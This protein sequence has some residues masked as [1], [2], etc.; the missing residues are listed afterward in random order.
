MRCRGTRVQFQRRQR[1]S[2]VCIRYLAAERVRAGAHTPQSAPLGRQGDSAQV[3]SSLDSQRH[4]DGPIVAQLAVLARAIERVDDPHALLAQARGC[5]G[6][7]LRKDAVV[8]SSA[9]H[10]TLQ[11]AI[12]GLVAN[13]GQHVAAPAARPAQGQGSAA[14]F[15][16]GFDG[17]DEV[18]VQ[19]LGQ[20]SRE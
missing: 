14:G 8:R 7:L 6:R 9:A 11:V 4:M 18:R 1:G 20:F 5:V 12:C 10:Q 15:L 16:C 3:T 17:K 2:G 13:V 19:G